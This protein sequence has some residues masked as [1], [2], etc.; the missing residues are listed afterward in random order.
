MLTWIILFLVNIW[1]FT[2]SSDDTGDL[3]NTLG[4]ILLLPETKIGSMD[5][6]FID[7]LHGILTI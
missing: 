1:T 3:R 7:Y 5:S 4:K 6:I 2:S